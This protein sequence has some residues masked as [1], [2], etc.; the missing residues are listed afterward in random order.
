MNADKAARIHKLMTTIQ[1]DL[2][3]DMRELEGKPF[4]GP[5]V[6]S[7]IGKLAA[8]VDALSRTI[9]AIVNEMTEVRS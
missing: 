3:A 9:E 2:E 5:V 6:A 4:T 8:T 7:H 1:S